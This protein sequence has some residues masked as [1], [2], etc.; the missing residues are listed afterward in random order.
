MYV[1]EHWFTH[2]NP[3]YDLWWP[4]SI[5]AVAARSEDPR[6]HALRSPTPLGTAPAE[7][8][9]SENMP[10]GRWALNRW[11]VLGLALAVE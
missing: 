9:R 1:Q 5:S 2:S 3:Q 11:Q 6:A 4:G 7:S 10:R 8:L